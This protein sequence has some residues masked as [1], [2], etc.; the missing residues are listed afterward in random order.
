[1]PIKSSI[2]K[3][4]TNIFR[5]MSDNENDSQPAPKGLNPGPLK[6]V[7]YPL[8]VLYCGGKITMTLVIMSFYNLTTCAVKIFTE[9]SMPLEYCEYYP[10]YEKCKDWLQKNLPSEF[11]KV[12]IGW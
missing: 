6:G 11:N 9:C 2:L 7:N 1:M 12:Q 3:T 8:Q 5:I 4:F 10:N